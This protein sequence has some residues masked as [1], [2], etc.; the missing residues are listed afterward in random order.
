MFHH[1]LD[2]DGN[3][4]LDAGE[5]LHALRKAGMSRPCNVGDPH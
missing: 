1:E 2:L 3:G 4:R 5:L